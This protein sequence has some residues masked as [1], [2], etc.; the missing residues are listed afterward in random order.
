MI[1]GTGTGAWFTV[2]RTDSGTNIIDFTASGSR[3]GYVG[4]NGSDLYLNQASAANTIFFTNNTE[5]M[6]IDSSGNVG[7]GTASP[8]YR[9]HVSASDTSNVVGGS[10]A[11]IN[12]SNSNAAAFGRTVDLDFSVGGGA[13]TERIAGLSAVYTSYGTSV[14]GALAFCT[15]NGSSSFAERMRIDSSGNVGIGT[16]SPTNKLQVNGVMVGNNAAGSYTKGF[17]GILTTTSTSTPTG[18]SSGDFTLIY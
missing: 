6:R 7:I 1:S 17:G 14:G 3:L 8:S 2:N 13:S 9:L 10:A 4:Y 5:R 18:G 16:A 12:I 15:N 11:A